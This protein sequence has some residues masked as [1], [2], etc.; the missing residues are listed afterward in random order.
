MGIRFSR[1]GGAAAD[2]NVAN[3]KANI[4][5][6]A[7][8]KYTAD[9]TPEDSTEIVKT[10]GGEAHKLVM[11]NASSF[12]IEYV[13][14]DEGRMKQD[15]GKAES[16]FWGKCN[17]A[18]NAASMP[19]TGAEFGAEQSTASE[20]SFEDCVVLQM[21]LLP[22]SH[23][24]RFIEF[25]PNCESLRVRGFARVGPR[26]TGVQFKSKL[27]QRGSKRGWRMTTTDDKVRTV[28]GWNSQ[29]SQPHYRK[30]Q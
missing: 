13:V 22:N 26:D 1:K 29:S 21:R 10:K 7:G 8:A 6:R 23:E 27:Y 18:L 15:G 2:K 9:G 14:I 5:G 19:A 11:R 3:S 25:P 24:E 28:P 12:N 16:K 30:R 20:W 17:L 4:G